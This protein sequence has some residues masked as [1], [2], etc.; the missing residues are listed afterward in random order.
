M[1][2]TE[3]EKRQ[4]N[5]PLKSEYEEYLYWLICEKEYSKRKAKRKADRLFKRG[6]WADMRGSDNE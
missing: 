4:I 1:P 3:E 5:E 6:K 2:P